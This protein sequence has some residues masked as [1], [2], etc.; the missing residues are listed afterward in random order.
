M[1]TDVSGR[2]R[3]G[4]LIVA[5]LI[6]LLVAVAVEA[7]CPMCRKALESPEGRQLASAFNRAILLLL[8]TP[9]A[10]VGTIAFLIAR[11]LRR[12]RPA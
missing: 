12:S 8:A 4:L 5:S 11:R 3:V 2:R 6:G 7:Q 9:F 1:T 10:A